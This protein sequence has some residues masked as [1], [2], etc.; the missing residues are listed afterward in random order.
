MS[1]FQFTRPQGARRAVAGD[2]L[3]RDEVSIHAPARGATF[4][5]GL[6]FRKHSVSIHAPAR[7][8]TPG[9]LSMIFTGPFQFTRPQGARQRLLRMRRSLFGFNSR[10]RKGRD[11]R[12]GGVGVRQDCFNSRARKGRDKD[13]VR[14]PHGV[15]GFNSR[16]R[17]GRDLTKMCL[18]GSLPSFNSRARKGRDPTVF[19]TQVA[20]VVSIHAPARGATQPYL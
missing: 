11:A 7:G 17:K 13:A 2:R 3:A 20:F 8:A 15:A 16:A 5:N 9:V 6:Q 14:I 1:V 18:I 10:A 19:V 12:H 4:C